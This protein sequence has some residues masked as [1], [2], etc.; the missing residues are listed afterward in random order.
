[1]NGFESKYD[2]VPKSVRL[3]RELVD[4]VETQPGKDFSKKLVGVLVEYKEGDEYRRKMI[5]RYDEQ[6]AERRARLESLMDN[7]NRLSL[8]SRHVD[9]VVKD[10]D[11]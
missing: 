5:Q 2:L 11:L 1:M 9:T 8:V 10:L 4:F 6:I 3:P 7:I